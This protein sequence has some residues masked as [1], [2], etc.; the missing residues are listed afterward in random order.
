MN[1]TPS[2]PPTAEDLVAFAAVV[3]AGGFSAAARALGTARQLVHRRVVALEDCTGLR[4]LERSTRQVRPTPLGMRVYAHAVTVRDALEAAA[5][6][7]RS[8]RAEPSG[9]LRI[10]APPLFTERLLPAVVIAFC[11]RWPAVQLELQPEVHFSDLIADNVDLALRIGQLEPS[12]LIARRL[13][14][15]SEQA[16]VAAPGF[17]GLAALAH[18]LDLRGV[19]T[20]ILGPTP[21]SF[22]GVHRFRRGEESMEIPVRPRITSLS[23]AVVRTAALAALG[24]AWLPRFYVAEELAAGALVEVL[25]EWW[26]PPSP[27]HAVLASRTAGNPAVGA[28]LLAL[29]DALLQQV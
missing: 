20:L 8:S 1:E 17:P 15:V 21:A 5:H 16:L 26:L 2:G 6:E 24:V 13:G 12:T 23:P 14:L 27:V 11:S 9:P 28:F 3:E 19:P 4:L 10:S 7:V 29:E 18:P 25:R 22:R